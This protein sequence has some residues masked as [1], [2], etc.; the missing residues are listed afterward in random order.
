MS[1]PTPPPADMPIAPAAERNRA[2]ILE[3]LRT[4]LR[5]GQRILEIGSGTGQHA[6]AFTDAMPGLDWLPTDLAEVLPGL[7]IRIAREGG[8]GLRAPVELDVLTGPWPAGPFDAVYTAN[9]CHIMPWVAVEAMLAGVG[10]GLAG[11]WS[12]I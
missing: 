11:W 12:Y 8:T 5:P 3:V 2:P 7:R 9:T 4:L 6:V 1:T 10:R